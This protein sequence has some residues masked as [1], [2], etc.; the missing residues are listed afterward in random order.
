M[1]PD[2]ND[3]SILGRFS[4]GVEHRVHG[5]LRITEVCRLQELS[6][7]WHDRVG[8]ALETLPW[9]VLHS[10]ETDGDARDWLEGIHIARVRL[11]SIQMVRLV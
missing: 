11:R 8:K 4:S 10:E 5:F 7:V 2:A 1:R 9:D 3:I 6:N